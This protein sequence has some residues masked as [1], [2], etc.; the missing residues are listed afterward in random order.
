MAKAS[1]L[2]KVL[3]SWVG[4]NEKDG[5]HKEIID[6]YNSE[7]PLPR[8]YK[9][10]HTDS[11][12]ATTTSAAAIKCAA[13]DIIPIECGCGEKIKLAQKMGIW[14]ENENRVPGVGEIVLYDW[15]DGTNFAK[16][17]NKGWPEHE[18]MVEMVVGNK[19]NVIEGN[20]NDAVGRR[21]LG[22]NDRY[23]RG[24]IVPKYEAETTQV[25][26]SI[27]ATKE[28]TRIT[29]KML[30]RGCKGNQVTIFESL[31]KELGYY[32][33]EIDTDFGSKCVEACN[34]FQKDYP[35][36]GT[37]GKP[38]GQFGS[39]SWNKLFSLVK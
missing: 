10:K 13:T 35:E 1:E 5:S 17:D 19:I 28:V 11:W 15:D 25:A 26:T 23:I 9:V 14:V 4:K 30:E 33:G 2:I 3:Q 32:K 20:L 34:A 12:C 7:K 8:G 29:M 6:I 18:G 39:K 22:V 37:D 27:T 16:T 38:D 31:M 36:C 24:Y 21:V